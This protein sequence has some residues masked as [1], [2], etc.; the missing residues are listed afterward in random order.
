MKFG[1]LF[2]IIFFVTQISQF[3]SQEIVPR[4]EEP[5]KT[6]KDLLQEIL[7]KVEAIERKMDAQ[8]IDMKKFCQN[9][10]VTKSEFQ[11]F[12]LRHFPSS[13]PTETTSSLIC[14]FA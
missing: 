1:K 5:A 10:T 11:D 7:R 13:E 8:S 4:V 14:C 2:P 6:E 12:I 3:F 9:G